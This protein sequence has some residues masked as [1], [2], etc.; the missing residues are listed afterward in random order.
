M[1]ATRNHT[2]ILAAL[3]I[4]GTAIVLVLGPQARATHGVS[5]R[6]FA[7]DVPFESLRVV[8]GRGVVRY[9]G[10]AYEVWGAVNARHPDPNRTQVEFRH[11]RGRV[12]TGGSCRAARPVVPLL[13][14]ACRAPDGSLWSV[15]RFPRLKANFGGKTAAPELWVSHWTGEPPK[16]EAAITCHIRRPAITG[17]YTYRG[18]GVHG[19][20]ATPTGQ[21]LDTYGRNVY[22]DVLDAPKYGPGWA[23]ENSFL[24]QRPNGQVLYAFKE[25][26]TYGSALRLTSVGPGVTPIVSVTIPARKNPCA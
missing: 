2:A 19:F 23:R 4:C 14:K 8:G 24:A 21:P 6:L 3:C 5:A 26:S 18:R 17:H 1:S 10:G 12:T 9:R 11:T 20:R 15:Q 16:L 22:L 25:P 13:V 7:R